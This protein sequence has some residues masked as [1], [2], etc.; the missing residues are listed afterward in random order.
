MLPYVTQISGIDV[1]QSMVDKFNAG[2]REAGL[3]KIHMYPVRG[4]ILAQLK[5]GLKARISSALI[6]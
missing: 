1:S 3:S 2:A 6:W 4:D 5:A